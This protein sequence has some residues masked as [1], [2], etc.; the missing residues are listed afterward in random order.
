MP[1]L[2]KIGAAS[3]AAFGF[4][5][6]SIGAYTLSNS[7]RFRSSATAYLNR[8]PTVTSNQQ[9]LTISCWVKR[10]KL[11]ASQ[12][13]FQAFT[14]GSTYSYLYFTSSD[15][16]NFANVVS[17]VGKGDISTNAVFRDPAAW[18]HIVLSLNY[19][20]PSAT[21]YINGVA[22]SVT[23]NTAL[24]ASNLSWNT[25]GVGN[26]IAS[27]ATPA[28]TF[29]GEMANIQFIDGQ[30]LTP[31]SF[32]ATDAT[33]GAW[34]P[35]AYTGS[36]G[37]NGFYLPFTNTTSTATLGNDS[38]GNSN[39]WT[40][41][42]IS[43]TAGSTYDSM[44]DVPTLTS[45]TAANYAVL[46]T[47]SN[48]PTGLAIDG[49]LVGSSTSAAEGYW[50]STIAIPTTDKWYWEAQFV[51]GNS[52]IRTSTTTSSLG[53]YSVMLNEGGKLYVNGADLGVV[54]STYSGTDIM[55]VTVDPSTTTIKWYKNNT[56]NYTYTY[57]AQ[58][59]PLFAFFGKYS[60]NVTANFGQRPFSYT[61]PSGFLPLNTYN[62]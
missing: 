62:L 10:G 53:T 17:S 13:L 19:A 3:L 46:N 32:G 35:I 52:G 27:N 9:A 48:P 43:L 38:S 23:V 36:Y 18:Y 26:Y 45:A 51:T 50:N 42:N 44:T 16:L 29:D 20:T 55:G 37:T 14:S 12:N 56:L 60:N 4:T 40:V 30:A 1:R 33:T 5:A 39:T 31:S 58:T 21:I 2:S 47:L 54:A 61:P 15:V 28:N 6:G 49:N 25:S 22:Q 24:V 8:T 34:Q 59:L 7:L 41:N 57:T 11:G